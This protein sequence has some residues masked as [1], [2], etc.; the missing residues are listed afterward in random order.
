[1]PLNF[2][3]GRAGSGK[4][5]ALLDMIAT[6]GRQNAA[7]TPC[8]LLVP[9]TFSHETER[10][11]CTHCGDSAAVYAEVITFKR[12]ASRLQLA[13]QQLKSID[14][15]G[16]QLIVKLAVD[17]AREQMKSSYRTVRT[18]AFLPALLQ[19]IDELQR[20]NL[21]PELLA[22]ASTFADEDIMRNK[23]HDLSLLLSAYQAAGERVG[24]NVRDE[25]TQMAELLPAS[26]YAQ[27]V[28]L[29]IDGF[30]TFTTAELAVL[31]VFF[32]QA[33]DV[34]VAL[35]HDDDPLFSTTDSTVEQLKSMAQ[36]CGREIKTT[37]LSRTAP[38]EP[39]HAQNLSA[40][41]PPLHALVTIY[42]AQDI[43]E[44]C[45]IAAAHIV[46]LIASGA[47]YRDIAVTARHIDGYNAPL[48]ATF[49]RYGIPLFA[50]GKTDILQKPI[51][52]ALLSALDCLQNGFRYESVF[53]YLRTGLSGLTNSE[54]DKLE[55]YVLRLQPHS[56][57]KDWAWHPDG[58]RAEWESCHHDQL[59][60]VNAL[61]HKVYTPLQRL[62]ETSKAGQTGKG[63]VLALYQFIEDL[64]LAAQLE[65]RAAQLHAN[66]HQQLAIE[67]QQLWD[68]ACRALTQCH[69]IL[70]DL[71]LNL[72]QFAELFK[73]AL[74][75]YDVGAIPVSL[76]C[77]TVGGT[78]RLRKR[79]LKHLILLGADDELLA[80]PEVGGL[81]S[82]SDRV[83][84][85]MLGHSLT[86]T[87]DKRL[88]RERFM[89]Y[90]AVTLPAESLSIVVP[91]D[92]GERAENHIV[93]GWRK[94]FDLPLLTA[95]AL[96]PERIGGSIDTARE[97]AAQQDTE[98]DIARALLEERGGHERYLQSLDA[99][100][101]LHR[102]PLSL[103]HARRLYG[104][105]PL[106]ATR[107][108]LWQKCRFQ[109]FMRYGLRAGTRP[110]PGF[111]GLDSGSFIH[112]VIE[113]VTRDVVAQGGFQVIAR[114]EIAQL[115]NNHAIIYLDTILPSGSKRHNRLQT[116]A[117]RLTFMA[118]RVVL[119]I[120]DELKESQFQPLLIEELFSLEFPAENRD[121]L[122]LRGVIDR[123]DGYECDGKLYLRVVD[124]KSGR[125]G[126]SLN[127]L[128][129]GLSLQLFLYTLGID[130]LV[131]RDAKLAGLLYVPVH[132]AIV[133]EGDNPDD[134]LRRS[135][136]LLD[137][138][139]LLTA[140][141][142]NPGARFLPKKQG[143]SYLLTSLE[144]WGKMQIHVKK[145]IEQ[146]AHEI[147]GGALQAEPLVREKKLVCEYCDFKN[148]C[149]FDRDCEKSRHFTRLKPDEIVGRLEK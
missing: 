89:F 140:M 93:K 149:Q 50:D 96:M 115:A 40:H 6:N 64:Q 43:R 98:G 141:E 105:P 18:N 123:V 143:D 137:N 113:R 17:L 26:G 144:T 101:N 16:R 38:F 34:H 129:H 103:N 69:H 74:S 66:G 133:K 62:H 46:K 3:L 92:G 68:I 77:V 81:L 117:N 83:F 31:H 41:S 29:F 104:N 59:N 30:V 134:K 107:M 37:K 146:L 61:R 114:E 45:D 53:A 73:L 79:Q 116:Y 108:D 118:E 56:W 82:E 10:L 33:K 42:A 67:T 51:L 125:N 100:R 11:L 95:D 99:A 1:M 91:A 49:A 122:T 57:A 131:N 127:D 22:E 106:S 2:I 110:E 48:A 138:E 90:A 35:C 97:A 148:A 109:Y 142:A 87:L 65:Q 63:Q 85:E 4:S 102:T 139:S 88:S 94:A 86:P 132:E 124:Y 8:L 78:D 130:K 58:Y 39:L 112:A 70:G 54:C 55:A 21:T 71:P 9:E 80:P 23:L 52:T 7:P 28:R 20:G 14:D 76:D 75:H 111:S 72:P 119:H 24:T 145:I 47:R 32:E 126:F 135:G 120:A 121:I 25:L 5:T 60:I 13:G 15:S 44:Q 36:D 27:G 128:Y 12:L 19:T 147:H 136:L 84:L